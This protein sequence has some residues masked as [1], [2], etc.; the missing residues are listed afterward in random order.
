MRRK[1]CSVGARGRQDRGCKLESSQSLGSAGGSDAA[2]RLDAVAKG[3]VVTSGVGLGV[4]MRRALQSGA[5][6][7]ITC[8][9]DWRREGRESSK[10][11]VQ[12]CK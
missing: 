9:W 6:T 7:G 1:A 3:Q 12:V 8:E 2:A 5:C 11:E 4:L 10:V